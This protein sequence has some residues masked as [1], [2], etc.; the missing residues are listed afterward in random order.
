[1]NCSPLVLVGFM[2]RLSTVFQSY[3]GFVNEESVRDNSVRIRLR[4]PPAKKSRQDTGKERRAPAVPLHGKSFLRCVYGTQ[5]APRYSGKSG[6]VS[7]DKR[8][9]KVKEHKGNVKD[10]QKTKVIVCP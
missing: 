5:P 7:K 1:M 8:Q 6:C 10:T 2:K 3:F 4:V 9:I